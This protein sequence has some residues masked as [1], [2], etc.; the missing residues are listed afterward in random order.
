MK[1]TKSLNKNN[2]TKKMQNLFNFYFNEKEFLILFFDETTI[3][4]KNFKN[5]IYKKKN[6]KTNNKFLP[7]YFKN[8]FLVIMNKNEIISYLLTEENLET[9]I[10]VNFL[11]A[12][13][14]FLRSIK[15]EN[16][17]IIIFADNAAYHRTDI[18]KKMCSIYQNYIIFNSPNSPKQNP[19]ETVFEFFK[20]RIRNVIFLTK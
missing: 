17:K 5:K 16:R 19:I 10:V 15:R 1:I 3:S 13:I 8:H 12:T 11:I 6:Q 9:M 14:D 2:K 7:K 4:Q 18:I 20:R